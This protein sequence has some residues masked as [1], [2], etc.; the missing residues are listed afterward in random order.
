MEETEWGGPLVW[1][2]PRAKRQ[3]SGSEETGDINPNPSHLLSLSLRILGLCG[4]H[5]AFG[6]VEGGRAWDLGS[7]ANKGEPHT[8]ME[9]IE[10]HRAGKEHVLPRL[11]GPREPA[12]SSTQTQRFASQSPILFTLILKHTIWG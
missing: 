9:V 4:G 3:L 5:V 8:S 6:G 2:T 7:S 12:P 10:E 1:K 11:L